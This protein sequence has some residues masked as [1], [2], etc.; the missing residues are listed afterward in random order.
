MKGSE[1]LNRVGTQ[2]RDT[3]KLPEI[4][5]LSKVGKASDMIKDMIENVYILLFLV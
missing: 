2:L 4:K 1:G 5:Y 3:K